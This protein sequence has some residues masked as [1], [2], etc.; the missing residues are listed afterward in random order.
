[1]LTRGPHG[2]SWTDTLKTIADVAE[3][4]V[5][6]AYVTAGREAALKAA[7]ALCIEVPRVDR[8]SDF[9]RK[10]LAPPPGVTAKLRAGSI[11]A[12]E[13][14]LGHKFER[15]H[16]LA[17][18]LVSGLSARAAVGKGRRGTDERLHV[19][20]IATDPWLHSRL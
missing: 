20:V 4:I 5:G 15:P 10:A 13:S 14:I 18:A 2:S 17:Q 1:M 16:L 7:K 11:E 6:A 9:G 8:W 3:A 12:V 19:V